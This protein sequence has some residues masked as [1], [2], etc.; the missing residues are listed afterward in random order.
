MRTLAPLLLF[1]TACAKTVTVAVP[2]HPAVE[3]GAPS[4]AIIAADTACRPVADD[5]TH[6]LAR[7]VRIDPTASTRIAVAGCSESL[8]PTI[9]IQSDGARS[10]GWEGRAQALIIVEQDG[11][12]L[13]RLIGT[14]GDGTQIM[15]TRRAR[16]RSALRE[17]LVADITDQ[18][19]PSGQAVRR[20]YPGASPDSPKGLETQAIAAEALG[21]LDRALDLA[22]AA[23]DLAPTPRL[24]AYVGELERRLHLSD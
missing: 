3:V 21:D 17:D 18:I 13:G 15:P 19:A 23:H 11:A 5:L 7:S 2:V 1:A 10:R 20:I 4:V 9:S 8:V 6:A 14:G 12:P 16:L 22:A 24:A